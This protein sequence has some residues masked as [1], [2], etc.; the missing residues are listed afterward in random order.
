MVCFDIALDMRHWTAGKVRTASRLR[1]YRLSIYLLRIIS[2]NTVQKT[3]SKTD[4]WFKDLTLIRGCDRPIV[5]ILWLVTILIFCDLIIQVTIEL[6]AHCVDL[7]NLQNFLDT[8]DIIYSSKRL[9]RRWV[10]IIIINQKWIR[11]EHI[12]TFLT[13]ISF[14]PFAFNTL[15]LSGNYFML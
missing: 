14:F 12:C 11:N 13:L 5:S 4:L 15:V 6:I 9:S 10:P 7:N 8:L 3:F 2:V 1:R